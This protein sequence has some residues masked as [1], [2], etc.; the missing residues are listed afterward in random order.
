MF[1]QNSKVSQEIYTQLIDRLGSLLYKDVLQLDSRKA[2]SESIFCAYPGTV[3]DSRQFIE[4]AINNGTDFILW[5]DGFADNSGFQSK[6]PNYPVKNLMLY[7]CLLDATRLD[8]P[9]LKFK[10]IGVTG[11][12]GKT[13]ISHWLSQVYCLL[14][15]KSGIIG[16]T[17]AGIYPE[18]VYNDATTPDPITLQNI[19]AGFAD[20]KVDVV[21][22][23][24]SSHALHQGRVN[25]IHFNTAIFTN[26]TQDHLDYHNNM[27]N[28]YLI[29]LH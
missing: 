4:S 7:V 29:F 22:M 16:T 17:G 24:V 3:T 28:Y 25:G 26:L 2:G 13:S 6:I 1:S 11:T 15:K 9:S 19:L 20:K 12:N 10:T 8:F 5:E 21:T 27:E 23:E 14:G 18:V